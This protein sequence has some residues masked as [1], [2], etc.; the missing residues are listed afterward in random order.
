LAERKQT[1]A[2]LYQA[3]EAAEI[4]NRAKSRFLANM[5]HE[6]RTPLNAILGYAELLQLETEQQNYDNLGDDIERIQLAG[7]HL[8]SLIGDILDLTQIEANR[9]EL[10][11]ERFEIAALIDGLVATVRPL[12]EKHGNALAI[13]CPAEI[14]TMYADLTRVR[15]VLLNVLANAAKFTQ[16]GS[17]VLRV[18]LADT[19]D[20]KLLPGGAAR[21]FVIF[22]VA[23]TGIGMTQEQQQRL[24]GE[25]VQADDASTR[26]YGGSGLGL[27]ISYRLCQLM[28]GD[29][30]VA[31][32]PGIGSAFT[33]RLPLNG[34]QLDGAAAETAEPTSAAS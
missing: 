27:A 14:E 13:E 15:Q 28:G 33:V 4:A 20:V 31:S 23:D 10:H 32:E 22:Q 5:S 12:A 19:Q 34:A 29:I 8:L 24:F 7:R 26:K 21:P 25:F 30:G 17:I 2:S 3:K 18:S 11:P 6:L 16:H 1:E 9:I